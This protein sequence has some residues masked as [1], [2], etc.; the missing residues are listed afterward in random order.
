MFTP[1]VFA[2]TEVRGKNSASNTIGSVLR[3]V[4]VFYLFLDARKIDIEE[5]LS[6]GWLRIIS[7]CSAE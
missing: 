7:C 5:R 3:S 4:M 2:L 6:T 1:T